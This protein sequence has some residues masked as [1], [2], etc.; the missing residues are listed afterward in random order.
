MNCLDVDDLNEPVSQVG[1]GPGKAEESFTFMWTLL[2]DVAYN[3]INKTKRTIRASTMDMVH[4][5]RRFFFVF[6]LR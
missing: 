4:V 3:D 6:P 5:I 1:H 2:V